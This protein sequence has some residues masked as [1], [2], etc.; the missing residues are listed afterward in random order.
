[1]RGKNENM[2]TQ[3]KVQGIVQEKMP[4]LLFKVKLDSGN[5]IISYLS[6]KMKMNK[7]NVLIGDR[8]EIVLDPA[9]GKTTNRLVRR[10]T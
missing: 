2:N 3:E 9:G 1:M 6:G 4:N 7:I 8:V 10:L 5:E